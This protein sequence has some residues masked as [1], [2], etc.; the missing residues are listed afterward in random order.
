MHRFLSHSLMDTQ[1]GLLGSIKIVVLPIAIAM[2][3]SEM[4]ASFFPYRKFPTCPDF[5]GVS[6]HHC[7]AVL[8][9]EILIPNLSGKVVTIRRG[10]SSAVPPKEVLMWL[11]KKPDD[12]VV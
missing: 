3:S 5:L 12:S 10:G 11:D 4:K 6:C 2:A 7:G 8:K 1:G 9:R